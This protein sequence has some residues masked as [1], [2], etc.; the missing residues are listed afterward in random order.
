MMR[1]MI[2]TGQKTK[3]AYTEMSNQKNAPQNVVRMERKSKW[4]KKEIG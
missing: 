1:M 4:S 2:L 3:W